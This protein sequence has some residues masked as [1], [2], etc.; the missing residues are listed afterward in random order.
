MNR[1]AS[2][3]LTNKDKIV[4]RY[5]HTIYPYSLGFRKNI[6]VRCT[7]LVMEGVYPAEEDQ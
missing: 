6:V 3:R 7:G 4:V 1:T 5:A 2:E